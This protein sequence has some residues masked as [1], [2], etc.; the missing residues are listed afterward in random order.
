MLA[1]DDERE[2]VRLVNLYGHLIDQRRWDDLG[3]IFT[4]D[5]AFDAS[6]FGAPVR[7]SLAQL[8]SDWAAL[9]HGHPIAHHATN[10][11]ITPAAEG[12][13]DIHSKGLCLRADGSTFS[14]V[15]QDKAVRTAEG[16]RICRRTASLRRA[17]T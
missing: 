16:W 10:I 14:A 2:L 17:P 11:V 13:A 5:L 7:T 8:R 9:G 1:A 4:A 12:S 3:L 6:D 15:C